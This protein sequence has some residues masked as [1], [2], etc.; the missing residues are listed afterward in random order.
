MSEAAF[1]LQNPTEEHAILRSMVRDFTRDVVE[2][3]A[4]EH[5]RAATLNVELLRRCGELGLLGI[6]VPGED[7]GAGMDAVAAVIVHHE[8]AK[9]DPGFT[10]A[11]LAHAMLFVNN[12]YYASNPEQRSRYLP[13]VLTGEHIGAMGMTEPSAGTDVLGMKTTARREGDHYM[14]KGRKALITNAPEAD[15]FILYA[16][17]DGKIT[18]FMGFRFVHCERLKTGTDDQSGTSTGIPVFVKSAIHLGM[19]D[20]VS[21][22]ISKRND[23]QGEPWQAYVTGMFGATRIEERKIVRIWAR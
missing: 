4:E 18:S 20:D 14:L 10:L 13:K 1:D 7:G 15:V 9:S 8:L 5:D 12:F 2:P 22:S 23:L 16:T 21:T 11:Y 17:V 6:T 19:W 3:Q